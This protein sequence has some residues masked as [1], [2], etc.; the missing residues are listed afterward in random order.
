MG[1]ENSARILASTLHHRRG[2]IEKTPREK[3]KKQKRRHIN[4]KKNQ[5]T[6]DKK[7]KMNED[8]W[9]VGRSDYNIVN[10]WTSSETLPSSLT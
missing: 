8:Q 10:N 2:N 6:T 9:K 1:R 5:I 4:K 3:R 7:E